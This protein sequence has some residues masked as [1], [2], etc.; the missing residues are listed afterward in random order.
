MKT[1]YSWRPGKKYPRPE[2]KKLLSLA[3]AAAEAAGSG[4]CGVLSLSWVSGPE[5]AE[6]NQDSLG[7]TGPTD[8][9]CFDYRQ[10]RMELP[11]TGS[12]EEDVE[13][14]IVLCPAVAAK[15]AGKRALPYSRELILYLVHG[16]LHAAGQ[17]D[18]KPELKRAMRRR[19]ASVLR[20]LGKRFDLEHFFPEPKPSTD[21]AK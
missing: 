14:E 21:G 17:D 4:I 3:E 12:A 19:E 11:D 9:I 7:H 6:I 5:M 16:L 13:V 10:S 15:E 8:V 1:I 2:K 20:K 18:L